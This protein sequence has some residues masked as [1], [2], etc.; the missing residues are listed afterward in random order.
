VTQAK[1]AI[2]YFLLRLGAILSG[3]FALLLL[4]F[5]STC[6]FSPRWFLAF[7]KLKLGF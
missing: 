7:F 4:T 3:L 6:F 1:L 5:E 2:T